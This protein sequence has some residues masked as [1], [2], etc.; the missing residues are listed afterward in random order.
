LQTDDARRAVMG[1]KGFT[2]LETVIVLLLI[3]LSLGLSAV[4]F[5]G[6]LPAVRFDTAGR[7]LAATLRQARNLAR[8]DGE[9]R[10]VFIDLDGGTY[11]IGDGARRSIPPGSRL[12]VYDPLAGE[13]IGGV[14][15]IVF[16]PHGGMRGGT[17]WLRGEKK[18]L[19]VELDPILGTGVL[20]EEPVV[21]KNRRGV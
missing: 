6:F 3:S 20:R 12:A 10:T 1:N 11:G 5:A 17:V 16:H 4:Y 18:S 9:N 21:G 13:I 7:E 14:Y 8:L 19:R 15:T 2:L